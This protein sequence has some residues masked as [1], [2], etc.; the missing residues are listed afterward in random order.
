MAKKKEYTEF[1]VVKTSKKLEEQELSQIKEAVAKANEV[2]MQIGG[3]EAHKHAL[4]E[5]LKLLNKEV[6]STQKILAAKYGDVTI[7]LVTGEFTENDAA[8]K[9]D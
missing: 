8:D 2:Q 4:L 9:K 5:T 3:V 7:N 6:E 1:E